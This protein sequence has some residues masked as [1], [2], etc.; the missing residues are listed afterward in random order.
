MVHVVF[1][2]NF[3]L[4]LRSEMKIRKTTTLKHYKE[5]TLIHHV[6]SIMIGDMKDKLCQM[7]CIILLML[8]T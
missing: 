3:F 4:Y 2:T 1:Y 5:L 6:T 7:N 8:T